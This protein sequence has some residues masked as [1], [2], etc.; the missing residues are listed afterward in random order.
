MN[1]EAT[2]GVGRRL[3]A[4]V[5]DG[6]LVT[7]IVVVAQAVTFFVDSIIG[8]TVA[9]VLSLVALAFA[10]WNQVVRAGMKGASL[11]KT[12]LSLRV[13]DEKTREPIGIG[14]ALARELVLGLLAAI[15]LLPALINLIVTA[16]DARRQGWHDKAAA[17]LVV[18][19][20]E[21]P[22]ERSEGGAP[23]QQAASPPS[24]ATGANGPEPYAPT[25]PPPPSSVPTAPAPPGESVADTVTA[26][27]VR[28]VAPPPDSLTQP[29]HPVEETP[30]DKAWVTPSPDEESPVEETVMRPV[31]GAPAA[32]TTHPRGWTLTAPDGA[33]RVIDGPVLVGRDPNPQLVPGADLWPIDDPHLSMSKTHAL[34]GI[35]DGVAWVEDWASTNGVAL[36]RGAA[37]LVIEPHARTPLRDGDVVEFGACRV[38]V[39]AG[40]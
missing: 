7:V 15:C 29:T 35:E 16:K 11:G 5:I 30:V 36:H 3:A 26:P 9:M 6:L 34:L 22:A 1:R 38:S 32:P 27:P 18:T 31:S 25:I 4:R 33:R 2:A 8:A 10:L 23:A 21:A 19:P 28:M 14:R 17:S 12:W 20:G 13:V 24:L 37:Q 39:E 40:E